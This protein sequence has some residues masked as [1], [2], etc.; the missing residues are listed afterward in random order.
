MN[1]RETY[2][3]NTPGRTGSHIILE[4][5]SGVGNTAGGLGN[6]QCYWHPK[7]PQPYESYDTDQNIVI[8]THNLNLTV[9]NLGIDPEHAILILS[10]RKDKFA[11]TIS[12]LVAEITQEWNGK[13]YTDKPALP[14]VVSEQKFLSVLRS[15]SS[16]PNGNFDNFKKVVTIYY[17]DIMHHGVVHIANTLGI[18]YDGNK[19]GKINRPSPH[20]FKD[21]ITNW[22]DLHNLFRSTTNGTYL[23]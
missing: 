15:Y 18:Y 7:N 5:M 19:V 3:I 13:D 21:W 23:A 12:L 8:H 22:Q 1:T 6:A 4:A 9:A 14:T 17:E 11:Q 16:W 2:I 20:N 10:D